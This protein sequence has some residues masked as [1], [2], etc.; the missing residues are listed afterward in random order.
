MNILKSYPETMTPEI[1]Y[2]L[3]RSPKTQRMAD[4]KGQ[5][6]EVAAYMIREEDQDGK[7]VRICSVLTTDGDIFATN[8][9][10]F[11]REFEAILEVAEGCFSIEVIDGVSRAGR[12][13]VTCAW[14]H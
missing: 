13:F 6:L 4:V 14:A 8:S 3:M 11:N 12:H 9:A 7:V 2:D 1:K 5:T 10:T